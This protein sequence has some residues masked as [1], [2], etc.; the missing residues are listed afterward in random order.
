[1]TA[2]LAAVDHQR[3]DAGGF[4]LLRMLDRRDDVQPLRPD[5]PEAR[6]M[7][8]RPALRGDH[9]GNF[10]LEGNL[11]QLRRAWGGERNVHA[12]GLPGFPLYSRQGVLEIVHA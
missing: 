5:R 11:E 10:F 12:E 7:L 6:E 9:D 1:M 4:R 8:A 3:V 2:R